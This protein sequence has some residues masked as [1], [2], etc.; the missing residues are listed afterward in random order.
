MQKAPNPKG[1]N[2][3]IGGHAFMKKLNRALTIS[4][5]ALAVVSY[6]C[7]KGSDGAVLA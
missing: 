4:L 7:S 1:V 5:L 6:G 3:H 2:K